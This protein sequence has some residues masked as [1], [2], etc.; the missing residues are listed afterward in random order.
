MV[1]IVWIGLTLLTIPMFSMAWQAKEPAPTEDQGVIFGAFETP[2]DATI[3]QTSF[4]ADVVG[5]D[6]CQ[7]AG[8]GR[9]FSTHVSRF[10]DSAAWCSSRGANGS[11][12][13]S[14]SCREAQAMVNSIPGIHG[15]SWSRRRR[16]RRAAKIFRSI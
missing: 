16:C 4:Y 1:Y 10:A 15:F 7:G 14:K 9:R 6:V 2:P 13:F 12:P 11:G 3:E 5:R 8:G